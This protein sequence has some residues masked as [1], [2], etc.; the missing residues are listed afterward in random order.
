MSRNQ[1]YSLAILCFVI[2]LTS[3]VFARTG[4]FS[5]GAD[6][7]SIPMLRN[8]ISEQYLKKNLR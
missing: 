1:P 3:Q 2:S 5:E 7:D 6:A 4:S 8:P